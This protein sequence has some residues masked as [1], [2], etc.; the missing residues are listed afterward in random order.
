MDS[1][2]G[3]KVM[4]SSLVQPVPVLQLSHDFAACTEQFKSDMNKWLLDKFGTK[5]VAYVINKDTIV[6]NKEM[7][8]KIKQSIPE[9]Y[10]SQNYSSYE[11]LRNL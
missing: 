11:Y 7:L 5:E 2:F 1:I 9:R 3:M 10:I 6:L 4:T 8:S